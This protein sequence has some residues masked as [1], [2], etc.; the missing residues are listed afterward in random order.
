VSGTGGR[1]FG[2]AR[3]A[4]LFSAFPPFQGGAAVASLSRE[5]TYSVDYGTF[6]QSIMPELWRRIEACVYPLAKERGL[7]VA[8]DQKVV[9]T[10]KGHPVG[11]I[12]NLTWRARKGLG[13]GFTVELEHSAKNYLSVTV[14]AKPY[15][16]AAY[17]ISI[18]LGLVISYFWVPYLASNWSLMFSNI[19]MIVLVVI[20][21]VIFVV[22]THTLIVSAILAF[23]STF[24]FGFIGGY[25]VGW[26][27]GIVLGDRQHGGKV[28]PALAAVIAGLEI[29]AAPPAPVRAYAPAIAPQPYAGATPLQA[30]AAAAPPIKYAA[31]AA[32]AQAPYAPPPANWGAPAA[33]PQAAPAQA[34]PPGTAPCPQCGKGVAIGAP[35]CSWCGLALVW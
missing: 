15:Y 16:P 34:A 6:A 13:A 14:K 33:P 23:A 7:E 12:H 9:K 8:R 17:A 31:P 19:V 11:G 4:R 10:E 26:G 30:Y 2:R 21:W 18:V 32:S 29:P 27:V 20:M 28:R 35:S 24:A 22:L 25:A 3:P 1:G 5:F